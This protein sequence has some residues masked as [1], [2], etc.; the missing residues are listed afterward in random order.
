MN[1][2]NI[3]T[4]P[5]EVSKILHV[6]IDD[7]FHS[8]VEVSQSGSSLFEHPFFCFL[9]GLHDTYGIEIDIYVFLEGKVRARTYTLR[10]VSSRLRQD[11]QRAPWL[12]IG[13][14]GLN[15]CRAPYLQSD[16]EKIET[17]EAIYDEIDRFAGP[18]KQSQSVRLHYFSES[19]DIEEFWRQ[20]HVSVLFLTDKPAVSYHLPDNLKTELATRGK[21]DISSHLQLRRSHCRVENL[22]SMSQDEI[23]DTLTQFIEQHAFLAIFSHE[24]DCADAIVRQK[25]HSVLSYL[26]KS[27]PRVAE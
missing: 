24:K 25:F 13:P 19:F 20:N 7:V 8:L 14:H 17:F 9:K 2:T 26:C 5:S 27:T 1:V 3:K 11:F 21:L 4:I 23:V 22:K 16:A 15:Y 6:S 10:E 12:N 18:G